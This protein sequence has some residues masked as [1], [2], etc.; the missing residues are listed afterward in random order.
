MKE[1]NAEERFSFNN[2]N[3]ILKKKQQE[4]NVTDTIFKGRTYK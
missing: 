1:K 4:I 3:K 2:F